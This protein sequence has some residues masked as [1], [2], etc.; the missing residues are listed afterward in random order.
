MM[1]SFATPV[2]HMYDRLPADE[3]LDDD[4]EGEDEMHWQRQWHA[5]LLKIQLGIYKKSSLE[6]SQWLMLGLMKRKPTPEQLV[7]ACTHRYVG[8]PW[9]WPVGVDILSSDP[10]RHGGLG[11]RITDKHKLVLVLVLCLSPCTFLVD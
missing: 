9:R 8:G 11:I 3:R 7:N 4:E 5:N 6:T 2:K 10:S 1:L